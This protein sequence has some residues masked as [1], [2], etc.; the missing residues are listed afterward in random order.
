MIT[1]GY[2]LMLYCDCKECEKYTKYGSQPYIGEF[3]SDTANC[4]AKCFREAK[5]AGWEILKNGS[6]FAPGHKR[7]KIVNGEYI[8]D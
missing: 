6:C 3:A 5:K 8:D 4:R 1:S 2:T 7:R